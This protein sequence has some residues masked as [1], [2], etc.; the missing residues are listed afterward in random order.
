M[1][2]STDDRYMLHN[3][4]TQ[5]QTKL[6]PPDTSTFHS[7]MQIVKY[8]RHVQAMLEAA[9]QPIKVG[10]SGAHHVHWLIDFL[11]ELCMVKLLHKLAGSGTI[12]VVVA[13][14]KLH[15]KCLARAP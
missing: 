12:W 5:T 11:T 10:S 2:Q 14:T 4:L 15:V 3:I 8:S 13:S 7:V 9:R 6:S 1:G